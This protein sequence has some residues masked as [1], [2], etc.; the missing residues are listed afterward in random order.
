MTRWAVAGVG[1]RSRGSFRGWRRQVDA[2]GN[3]WPIRAC[4]EL[5]MWSLSGLSVDGLRR[6]RRVSPWTSGRM[7]V[8]SA[9]AQ[10]VEGCSEEDELGTS[11]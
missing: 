8:G 9:E 11:W 3:E 4:Q 1:G 6:L 5:A 2:P 7:E 10:P